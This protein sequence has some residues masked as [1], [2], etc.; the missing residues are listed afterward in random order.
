MPYIDAYHN[1]E[2]D[3]IHIVERIN[4]ERVYNVIPARYVFYYEEPNGRYRTMWGK[5]C[6][7]YETNNYNVFKKELATAKAQGKAIHECDINPIFRCLSENYPKDVIPELVLGFFDIETDFDPIRGFAPPDDPF[8]RITAISLYE[9]KQQKLFTL[10]LKPDLPKSHKFYMTDEQALE[11]VSEFEDTY[12]C[13]D[14]K[15]LLKTFIALI[16]DVDVLTGWNST[17]FDIPYI[18][19]RISRVLG[20]DYTKDL[21]LWGKHPRKRKYVKFKKENYTYELYGRVHLDYL[22]LFQ[23]HSSQELH[24]YRLDFVGEMIVGENKVPYEG[25]LD[26]LYKQ[27]F[28][29]FIEY[30]R[31]D[32]MLLVKIDAKCKYIDLAN[33]LAH[34]NSVLLQTT[35][36]SVQLIE[37]AIVNES[38]RLGLQAP[39][40]KE[41]KQFNEDPEDILFNDDDDDKP[42][43]GAYV[44]DPKVGISLQIGCIDINSLYPSTLRALNMGPETLVGQIRSD[45]T[46][47]LIDRRLKE[48]W[49]PNM[50]WQGIF[51]TLEFQKVHE[52]SDEPLIVDFDH[53]DTVTL[54]G[55]DIHDFIFGE[56]HAL[57]ISANG[58]IF[59][60]DVKA[61]IPGL[62]ENWYSE[63]KVMQGYKNFYVDLS[64]DGVELDGELLEQL[65]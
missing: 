28:K 43:V 51:S 61:V 18:V 11:I 1:R 60:N 31:Q 44:A 39:S 56:G 54:T 19:N 30:N 58:T 32:T 48:G 37:Q 10:V 52:K 22:E 38:W 62:L 5:P 65:K 49:K 26:Q 57:T 59:R 6:S 3:E 55:K 21:C 33:Q 29:K 34:N 47:E 17:G 8:A 9:S 45:L 25:T 14:E 64:G 15:Q 7:I 35:M 24:S 63:R 12:L 20:K 42:V 23:K 27:D 16:E 2:K 46:E 36:G 13:K 4:G 41:E 53:G 50:V 40:R